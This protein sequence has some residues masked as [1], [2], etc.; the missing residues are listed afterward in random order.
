MNRVFGI[1]KN[2]GLY[3]VSSGYF[4]GEQRMPQP[5]E[6]IRLGGWAI[7]VDQ[8]KPNVHIRSG[9]V[10]DRSGTM[11]VVWITT[12]VN[13]IGGCAVSPA[14]RAIVQHGSDNRCLAPCGDKDRKHT[15]ITRWWKL[16][17]R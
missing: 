7:M 3:C 15:T 16:T 12:D 11:W 9:S 1:V 13:A 14:P 10:D 4:I 2:N 17:C 6:A 5:V 8:H